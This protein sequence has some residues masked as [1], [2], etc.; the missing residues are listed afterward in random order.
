[1]RRYM[2]SASTTVTFVQRCLFRL[3]AAKRVSVTLTKC[4]SASWA[5]GDLSNS[6]AVPQT[7]LSPFDIQHLDIAWL[8]ACADQTDTGI[9]STD[10]CINFDLEGLSQWGTGPRRAHKVAALD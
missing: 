8:L 4:S 9:N 5:V 7:S 2:L 1:M 3:M 10:L 6:E